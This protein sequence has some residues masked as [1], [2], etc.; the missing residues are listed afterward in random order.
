MPIQEKHLE[1]KEESRAQER[2]HVE[3]TLLDF[4]EADYYL[5]QDAADFGKEERIQEVSVVAAIQL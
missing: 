5:E 3:S 4:N 2:C 1:E